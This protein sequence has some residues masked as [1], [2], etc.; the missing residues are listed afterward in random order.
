MGNTNWNVNSWDTWTKNMDDALKETQHVIQGEMLNA[1][2]TLT[3]AQEL[4][5]NIANVEIGMKEHLAK[6]IAQELLKSK[7]ISFTKKRDVS[8]LHYLARAFLVPSDMVQ[9]LR[10]VK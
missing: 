3:E 10:Q 7:Y 8:G 4:T 5:L 9:I 2:I 1:K 6:I